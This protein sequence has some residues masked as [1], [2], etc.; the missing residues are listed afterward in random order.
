MGG[1]LGVSGLGMAV[2][3]FGITPSWPYLPPT[4]CP[5]SPPPVSGLASPSLSPPKTPPRPIAPHLTPPP[6]GAVFWGVGGGGGKPAA[7]G[8]RPPQRPAPSSQRCRR[9]AGIPP[10]AG[11]EGG[12]CP[13]PPGPCG[14]LSSGGC[15]LTSPRCEGGGSEAERPVWGWEGAS[16][17]RAAPAPGWGSWRDG[18]SL[19][20]RDKSRRELAAERS[21]PGRCL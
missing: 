5:S 13:S 10:G 7:S 16:G 18:G 12:S 6:H 3:G 15:N 20:G 17:L 4:T 21:P 2:E 8:H 9:G 11:G 19:G 1:F 14:R